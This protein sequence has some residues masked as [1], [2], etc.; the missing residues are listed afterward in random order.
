[1]KILRDVIFTLLVAAIIFVGLQISIKSFEVFN[2]S[3]LPTFHEG[4]LII[5]NK[6]GYA[7]ATSP[8]TKMK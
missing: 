7:F 3:M 8:K 5:V 6:L 2:I 1:M 4:D